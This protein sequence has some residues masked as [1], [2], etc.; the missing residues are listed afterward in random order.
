MC[1]VHS[2]YRKCFLFV[3]EKNETTTKPNNIGNGEKDNINVNKLKSEIKEF[4]LF[5]EKDLSN[6]SIQKIPKLL[7]KSPME[8]SS[9]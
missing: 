3:S 4:L 8:G 5:K 2:L 7:K 6:N 9:F 1:V